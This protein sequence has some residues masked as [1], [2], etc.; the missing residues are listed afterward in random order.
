MSTHVLKTWPEP[1]AAI[2]RGDKT[3][4]FRKDDRGYEVGDTLA[5]HEWDPTTEAYSGRIRA[6]EV[7][8]IR[9]GGAFGIPDGYAMLSIRG[10]WA[11]G[12]AS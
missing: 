10:M 9:R 5:L 12:G 3:A 1:F 4:E 6:V 8:D 11:K 7:T 2:V